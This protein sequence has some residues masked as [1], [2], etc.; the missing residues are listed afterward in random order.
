MS[1]TPLTPL[2][3]NASN[4]HPYNTNNSNNPNPNQYSNPQYYQSPKSMQYSLL[5]S[6]IDLT[7]PDSQRKDEQYYNSFQVMNNQQ[8][9]PTTPMHQFHQ[10]ITPNQHRYQQPSAYQHNH[11]HHPQ[12]QLT[13]PKTQSQT[14]KPSTTTNDETPV[15]KNAAVSDHE[16]YSGYL[17]RQKKE[18]GDDSSSV[19][20]TD[21][22]EAFMEALRKIPRVGRR[23][24]T[25]YGR[26]CGRNELISDYIYQKTGKVRTRKQV[27]SHIQVLKH[28]LK[29]DPEFMALV[30][31]SPPSANS[32][33]NTSSCSNSGTNNKVAMISPIF[34]KGSA[35]AQEQAARRSR[36]ASSTDVF[37]SSPNKRKTSLG[38]SQLHFAN[39]PSPYQ[40]GSNS[41]ATPVRAVPYS[42]SPS[43][44]NTSTST[45]TNNSFAPLNFCMWQQ[46]SPSNQNIE[47]ERP[48]VFS[49]LIRPQF[50]TPLKPKAFSDNI[51]DRFPHIQDLVS[52]GKLSNTPI[53]YCKIKLDI[54]QQSLNSF[55]P[56]ML[57]TDLQ[58]NLACPFENQPYSWS[59]STCVSTMGEQVLDMYEAVRF[60]TNLSSKCDKLSI[61]F[62]S[63]FW[64]AFIN[65]FATKS[66]ENFDEEAD[67]AIGAITVV[68]KLY[69]YSGDKANEKDLQ[70]VMVY[71]FERAHNAFEARTVFRKV[72]VPELLYTQCPPPPPEQPVFARPTKTTMQVKELPE[73]KSLNSS[74]SSSTSTNPFGSPMAKQQSNNSNM[75]NHNMLEQPVPITITTAPMTRS[76]SVDAIATS[77]FDNSDED[78]NHHHNSFSSHSGLGY[79]EEADGLDMVRSITAFDASSADWS[80]QSIVPPGANPQW[81]GSSDLFFASSADT[82]TSSTAEGEHIEPHAASAAAAI[83]YH[84]RPPPIDLTLAGYENMLENG[85][86]NLP[87]KSAPASFEY[88]EVDDL[89]VNNNNN[90]DDVLSND[91]FDTGNNYSY[92]SDIKQEVE[93]LSDI[94]HSSD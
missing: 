77:T 40:L 48:T 3:N 14:R 17:S 55:D 56:V 65:G 66:H 29:S 21:V 24:I 73:M 37:M 19:W 83:N 85:N 47:N 89:T 94:E 60:Q 26:P 75:T 52:Q 76:F 16:A 6:A 61:P 81:F 7:P 13:A 5:P 93:E 36:A 88:Y 82:S 11:N 62:A 72:C 50:E 86:E 63:E 34:S 54:S 30:A 71:E 43:S 42:P 31:D 33:T 41:G 9:N 8:Q 92:S 68:Q 2:N 78:D 38:S 22:E 58:F 53:A 49:Q 10:F 91:S 69:C 87:L 67:A 27:S 74:S 64:G 59:V 45:S 51:C 44:N 35:G 28:L 12:Q 23:K 1:C 80:L 90:N 84:H 39:H 70:S 15:V 46:L 32:S 25:I 79:P 4:Q 57:K 20:S 18:G